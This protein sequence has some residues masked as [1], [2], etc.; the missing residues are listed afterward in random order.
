[1]KNHVA[2]ESS[3]LCF[4]GTKAAG[5]RGTSG[6]GAELRAIMASVKPAVET[7]VGLR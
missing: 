4:G 7:G 3:Q 5:R 2:A 6:C 1:M